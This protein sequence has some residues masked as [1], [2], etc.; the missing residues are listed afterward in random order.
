MRAARTA[1]EEAG[2][3]P[4]RASGWA[5]CSGWPTRSRQNAERLVEIEAENTGKPKGLTLSEEI[6][7]MCDQIRFFAGAARVARRAARRPSTCAASRSSIRREPIGVIGS[8]APWNYPMMMAVWKFAPALAAGNTIVLK[9]SDTTPASAVYMA[10]LFADILPAGR[11]Q[12]R[13]RRPRHRRGGGQPP[14][15]GDGVDHRQRRGGQGGRAGGGRHAQA[16]PPRARRQGAGDRLRRRR[17]VRGGG[18]H[19][20]R[21]LLQRRPGLHGG[22]AR[23]R[24]RPGPRR[25]RGRAR[26]AGRGASSS[27]R[28]SS[29][30]PRTSSSRRSTTPTS[31]ATSAAWSSA[32]PTT[33]RC[34]RAAS[35]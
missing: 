15:P 19:R 14:D 21:R 34:S 26:R 8:V 32:R 20:D 28:T 13:L 31:S 9:P 30:T 33:P 2:A 11:L 6:P 29:R 25:P 1:F 35:A 27:P 24:R 22:H 4:P 23:A 10:E 12:R 3:T 7:P 18:G 5:T 16:L 17:P